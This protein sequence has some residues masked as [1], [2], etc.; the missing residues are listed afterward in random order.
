VVPAPPTHGLEDLGGDAGAL[1]DQTQHD[2]REKKT[3][4]GAEEREVSF[5]EECGETK[6]TGAL[7]EILCGA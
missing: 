4:G 1:T 5:S 7:N 2:L 3:R 6:K